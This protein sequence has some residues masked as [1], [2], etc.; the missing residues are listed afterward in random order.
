MD[1]LNNV[2]RA[3]GYHLNGETLEI[4]ANQHDYITAMMD[5]LD[6]PNH[7][8][9]FLRLNA[10]PTIQSGLVYI[11]NH[12]IQQVIVG[13]RRITKGKLVKLSAAN[14]EPSEILANPGDYTVIV[15]E[16]NHAVSLANNATFDN[17]YITDS[18]AIR[19]YNS[20]NINENPYTF[21]TLDAA[22][23]LKVNS[24][25]NIFNDLSFST[26]SQNVMSASFTNTIASY[27]Y[28]DDT[29]PD[30][31]SVNNKLLLYNDYADFQLYIK[32]ER[33]DAGDDLSHYI[34]EINSNRQLPVGYLSVVYIDRTYSAQW[35][36]ETI[37]SMHIRDFTALVQQNKIILELSAPVTSSFTSYY[38][39]TGRLYY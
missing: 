26:R 23:R 39:I 33:G 8:C 24:C 15:T 9:V 2:N 25:T 14:I 38:H 36:S 29:I 5:G 31:I 6:L 17:A 10:T 12:G 28:N 20:L 4:L 32:V 3:T 37:E 18:C 22:M 30:S 11:V 1:R 34:F 16:T 35:G 27:S 13:N 7:S 21:Y 19:A